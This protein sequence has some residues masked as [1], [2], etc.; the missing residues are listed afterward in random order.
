MQCLSASDQA[1]DLIRFYCHFLAGAFVFHGMLFVAN[2]TF[3]NL[4]RPHWATCFNFGRAVLGTIPA[5][6]LGAQWYGARGVMA[7]EAVGA[8]LFGLLAIVAAF[9]LVRR[10]ER[11]HIPVTTSAAPPVVE[12]EPPL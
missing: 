6:Y 8:L 9:A 12:R 11:Q 3:N 5:V 10:L 2:A 7:G 1:A 4:H